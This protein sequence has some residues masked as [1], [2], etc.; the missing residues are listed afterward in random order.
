MWASSVWIWILTIWANIYMFF[1]HVFFTTVAKDVSQLSTTPTRVGCK[2]V[3]WV[4]YCC[5]F[6]NIWHN[7][8]DFTINVMYNKA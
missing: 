3:Q 1:Y 4:Q 8:L 7:S 5:N 6:Y 2:Q